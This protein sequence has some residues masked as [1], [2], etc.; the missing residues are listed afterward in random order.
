[1]AKEALNI[2]LFSYEGSLHW[3]FNS[4]RDAVP[5]LHDFSESIGA[6]LEAIGEAGVAT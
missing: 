2:A 6:E 1:M 4:D 5:D 3:G